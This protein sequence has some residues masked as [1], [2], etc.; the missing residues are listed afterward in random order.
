MVI[1][2][3]LYSMQ[4]AST[5]SGIIEMST[6]LH[7][8]RHLQAALQWPM[9]FRPRTD[10]DFCADKYNKDRSG[11]GQIAT[12]YVEVFV[13]KIHK[14]MCGGPPYEA[15]HKICVF[16]GRCKCQTGLQP[17]KWNTCIVDRYLMGKQATILFFSH[18]E[19]RRVAKHSCI[20]PGHPTCISV[21]LNKRNYHE[22]NIP[23]S[24]I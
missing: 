11:L 13:E 23:H 21:K 16:A 20:W 7:S 22:P 19:D 9:H 5:M 12:C 3:T 10:I 1:S 24:R 6:S 2:Q 17:W 18:L 15:I 4:Q 14:H 8:T